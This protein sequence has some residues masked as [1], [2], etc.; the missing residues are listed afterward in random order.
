MLTKEDQGIID[1]LCG[2]SDSERTESVIEV[3][4]IMFA[5]MHRRIFKYGG[6]FWMI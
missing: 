2:H 1:W 3:A 5:S 6:P 4:K